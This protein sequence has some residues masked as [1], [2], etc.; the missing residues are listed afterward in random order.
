M[1]P[2]APILFFDSGVG[3]L[4]VLAPTRALLPLAP[5]VYAAD[6]AAFPY[7][8]RS[9]AEIAARVPALLGRLPWP[10]GF[11]GEGPPRAGKPALST[12]AIAEGRSQ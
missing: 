5:I 11:R 12:G 4:S 2:A 1:N 6:S 7:G 9:E 10:C 3:G 8:T